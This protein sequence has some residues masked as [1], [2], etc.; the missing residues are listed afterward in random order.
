MTNITIKLK[1]EHLDEILKWMEFYFR[2]MLWQV[3]TDELSELAF[4]LDRSFE[5][6][7]KWELL[8]KKLF[9]NQERLWESFS[10]THLPLTYEITRQML[11]ERNKFHWIQNVH[12]YPPIKVSK[13][14][15]IEV[16]FEK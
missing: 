14:E 7:E 13:E 8:T 3:K 11:F 2:F 15:L 9:F 1:E 12:S 16:I 6:V 4:K 5:E 10:Y